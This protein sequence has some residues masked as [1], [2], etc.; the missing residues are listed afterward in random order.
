MLRTEPVAASG[1]VLT[2]C[3]VLARGSAVLDMSDPSK[4]KHRGWFGSSKQGRWPK[5]SCTGN[6]IS[7]DYFVLNLQETAPAARGIHPPEGSSLPTHAL[8]KLAL[9]FL[10]FSISSVTGLTGRRRTGRAGKNDFS[11]EQ[12][13]T[14]PSFQPW[15][16]W[17]RCHLPPR[18]LSLAADRER[19]WFLQQDNI[20]ALQ[21]PRR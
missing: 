8:P 6:H 15:V 3:R 17:G 20:S 14:L 21:C 5:L 12:G 18:L 9:V 13:N 7:L 16:S 2:D 10:G 11:K 19:T 4:V 1:P